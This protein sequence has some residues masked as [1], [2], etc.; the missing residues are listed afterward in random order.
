[1][2]PVN[3]VPYAVGRGTYWGDMPDDDAEAR[4]YGQVGVRAATH[5]WRVY[6]NVESRLWDLHRLKHVVSPYVTA[7]LANRL[8]TDVLPTRQFPMDPD[9]EGLDGKRGVAVGVH[10]VLQTKRGPAGNRQNVDW[11]RLAL[12]YGCYDNATNSLP[13]DGRFFW[14]RPENSLGRSHVNLDYEWRISDA[15]LFTAYT[16]WDINRD[17]FGRYGAS[18]AVARNPRL[19]YLAGFRAI[20]D[21]DS[22]IGTFG[23]SYR[24]NR[25][26][27]INVMEQYD[28]DYRSGSN[29]VT[30]CTVTRKFPRWYAA[31]TIQY[32]QTDND[33]ALV[34]TFWPEGMPEFRVGEARL[35][36]L[37]R[38]SDN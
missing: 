18:L 17:K 1:L 38:S 14:Y 36:V 2:G 10:Q 13:A 19:R 31:F 29:L 30:T 4:W 21:L 11:M 24:I 28:F 37:G 16:N 12:T 32:D 6:N 5:F 34:L 15:T 20:P 3:V 25:K 26:Y 22:C 33:L 9:I 23:V 27:T 35:S 8:D 7:F